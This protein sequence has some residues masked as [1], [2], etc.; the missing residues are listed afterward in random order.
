MKV[1][2]DSQIFELQKFGGI[3]RY[4]VELSSA[5]NK[6]GIVD[7]RIISPFHQNQYLSSTFKWSK[8]QVHTP[9]FTNRFRLNSFLLEINHILGN[10][11]AKKFQPDLI[12]ETFYASEKLWNINV[13][14]VLTIFDLIREKEGEH[15]EKIARKKKSIERADSIICIS[16]NTKRDFLEFYDFDE[17]LVSTIH[18]APSDSFFYSEYRP[19]KSNAYLLYVGG[20]AGYKN[21]NTFAKAFAE[22]RILKYD[23]K[24][25]I[26]GGGKLSKEEFRVFRSL[27]INDAVT[28]VE[29]GDGQL[30]TFYQNATALIYPSKYEGFG[31]PVVEAMAS[32]CPVLCS[33]SSSLPEVAGNAALLFDPTSAE[34]ILETMIFALENPNVLQQKSKD[35]YTQASKF[36]WLKS[37]KETKRV[38]E[39]L[40]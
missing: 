2:F 27:G 11:Q 28:H 34:S 17:R 36:T 21:F 6:S 30:C 3:S 19:S 20:R 12:H 33:N 5:M 22:L 16:E 8:M 26:F 18:L 32:G 7:S 37:A 9:F 14:K 25:I 4:F 10:S 39:K 38:Y 24:L 31:L 40:L 29:G 15:K 1:A 23:I 13:P 35:G